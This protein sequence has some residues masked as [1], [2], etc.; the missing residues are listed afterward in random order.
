[1][2][3]TNA[4]TLVATA[5]AQQQHPRLN[6]AE[7]LGACQHRVSRGKKYDLGRELP[8]ATS[9]CTKPR[10]LDVQLKEVFF[11]KCAMNFV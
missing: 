1:M 4:G 8:H 9:L 11:P 6:S 3:L 7:Q 5:R 2:P 10:Y